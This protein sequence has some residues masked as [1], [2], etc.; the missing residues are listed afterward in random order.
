MDFGFLLAGTALALLA[1]SGA[2]YALY[3]I[4]RKFLQKQADPQV[5]KKKTQKRDSKGRF[6]KG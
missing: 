5:A 3:S 6:V 2:V 1:L 4:S